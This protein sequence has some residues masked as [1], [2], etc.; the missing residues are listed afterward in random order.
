MDETELRRMSVGHGFSVLAVVLSLCIPPLF[1]DDF[2]LLGTHVTW[3]CVC[4]AFVIAVN[5]ILLLTLKPNP[6]YKRTSFGSKVNKFSKSCIYF[7]ISCLVFHA[8]LFLYGAP[9]LESVPETFMFS[10]LLSSFITSRCLF[11]LGPN[12][13][14][15]VRVFSRD[16]A[17]CV[18]DHS[19]QITTL[20]SVLGAW[21]GAFPIPL[22]WERP[23]QVWPISCSLGATMG[24][25]AGLLFGPLWIYW[26]RKRLTYKNR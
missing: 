14:A 18:W 12:F 11:I 26:N 7:F 1:L 2:S 3:L 21:F 23:W 16:G 13:H 10:V 6:S 4:S 17:M 19:L 22:D 8:V 24:Y 5:I 20:G 25:V 15:W 9:L